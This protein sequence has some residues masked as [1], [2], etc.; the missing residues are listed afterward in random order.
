MQLQAQLTPDLKRKL[1][2]VK[3]VL[4]ERFRR[5]CEVEEVLDA[6]AE[7]LL[8]RLDPVRKKKRLELLRLSRAESKRGLVRPPE[9]GVPSHL[10][11]Q[12]LRRDRGQ[13]THRD[14]QGRCSRTKRVEI[15]PLRA[16]DANKLTLADLTTRCAHHVP[17]T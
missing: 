11:L 14:R 16:L 17:M 6:M 12:A 2:R 5:E 13:C 3:V 7:V 1:D 15:Y 10:K 9:S 4:S 8:E